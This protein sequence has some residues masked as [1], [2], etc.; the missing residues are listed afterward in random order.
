MSMKPPIDGDTK[1][2]IMG[3]VTN[4]KAVPQFSNI[5]NTVTTLKESNK[6]VSIPNLVTTP[7]K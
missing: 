2:G 3:T 7:G 6:Q 4:Q 1:P 5:P